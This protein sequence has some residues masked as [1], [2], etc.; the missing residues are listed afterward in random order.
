MQPKVDQEKCVGCGTCAAIAPDMFEMNDSGKAQ[1]KDGDFSS[2][3]DLMN[4]AK[5]SCPA[6]AINVE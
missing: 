4:Q 5:D 1:V 2:Q 3:E 6:N